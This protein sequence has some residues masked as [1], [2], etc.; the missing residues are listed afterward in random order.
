[1]DILDNNIYDEI[2]DPIIIISVFV[3]LALLLFF[4][5]MIAMMSEGNIVDNRKLITAVPIKIGQNFILKG[6]FVLQQYNK[7]FQN[8]GIATAVHYYFY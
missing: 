6:I 8:F 5:D 7:P 2:Y 3:G 4:C 1:M